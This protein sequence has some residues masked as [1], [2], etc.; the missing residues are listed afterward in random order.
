MAYTFNT[1]KSHSTADFIEADFK[2]ET[3]QVEVKPEGV[4]CTPKSQDYKF[5]VNKKVPKMGLMMIGWGGNNGTTVTAG[6]L[7]N[8]H[9][10]CW[11]D[12]RGVHEPNYYGSYTQSATMRLGITTEGEEIYAPYKEILPMVCPDD[13]VL[14]GWDISKTNMADALKRAQ[15]VDYDLQKQLYPYIKDW[16]PLPSIYYKSYIAANQ[17]DRADNVIPGNKQ[18]HLD[19]VRKNIRDFKAAHGLDRVVILWTATTERYVELKAGLNDTADNLL[20]AIAND[21]EEVSPS[22]IFATAAIL[23]GCPFVNGSPQNTLVPGVIELAEK[24]NGAVMGDDFKTGQTKIKSV[25]A[26]FLVSS[27]LKLQSIV[28]YN[29][30]GN[31]DGKNLSSPNQFRSK[32]ISKSNVVSDVVKSNTIMYKKGEHP[33]HV[34]VIKY[35]P[36]VG[37]SKR[38]MD[39]YTSEIFLGGHNTIALHNTCEDSLLAAPLMIDLAVLMEFM[40]RITYSVEGKEFSHFNAVMSFLSYLLKA[41]VVPKGTPV[42]N[43][44][45]KQRECL[46]NLFRALLGL[47]AENHML[48]EGKTQSFF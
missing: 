34:I 46:D 24:H 19:T 9:H 48:L 37:D 18:N 31:N 23:E 4:V 29:H 32:E 27:G 11:T 25:L 1:T 45:F 8:K 6:I 15:V 16:V 14:G 17:D 7:A 26:D 43:A 12:K 21:E 47:P 35:V 38:A 44:L 30:L 13:I 5:K 28:S 36:Y 22:T 3:T 10:L 39:E 42:V 40:T 41:P 33:D 2:Y 20:K